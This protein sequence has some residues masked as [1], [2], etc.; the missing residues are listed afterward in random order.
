MKILSDAEKLA[1]QGIIQAIG[2]EGVFSQSKVASK[3]GISRLTMTNLVSKLKQFN[4]VKTENMG[5]R[6]TYIKFI[7]DIILFI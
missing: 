4:I 7:D 2:D 3:V 6:G 5:S 1:L